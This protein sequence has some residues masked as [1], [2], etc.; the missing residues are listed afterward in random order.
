MRLRALKARVHTKAQKQRFNALV[1]SQHHNQHVNTRVI[2]YVLRGGASSFFNPDAHWATNLTDAQEEEVRALVE[3]TQTTDHH[4]SPAFLATMKQKY[5]LNATQA[6][7]AYDSITQ[8]QMLE[9]LDFQNQQ[10]Q[11]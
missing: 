3:D 9:S 8:A 1:R 7:E 10:Q 5:G 11:E 4:A 6:R 2:A